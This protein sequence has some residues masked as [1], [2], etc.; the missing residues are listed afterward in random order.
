M[1]FFLMAFLWFIM[2]ITNL[3]QPPLHVDVNCATKTQAVSWALISVHVVGDSGIAH[4]VVK[5]AQ[6]IWQGPMQVT[7]P[8]QHEKASGARVAQVGGNFLSALAPKQRQRGEPWPVPPTPQ[9]ITQVSVHHY[10]APSC[11]AHIFE[12][13]RCS[14]GPSNV[15]NTHPCHSAISPPDQQGAT[16]SCL[17]PLTRGQKKN[18][19]LRTDISMAESQFV[20][21]YAKSRT[22][23]GKI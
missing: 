17:Q 13:A 6:C 4:V 2:A 20:Y 15:W 9:S 21:L 23:S 22:K 12:H 10:P 14:S 7:W 3:G 19:M 11:P 1:L 5:C 18:L 8:L 16:E